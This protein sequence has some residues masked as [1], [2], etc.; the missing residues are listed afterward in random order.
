MS[1]SYVDTYYIIAQFCAPLDFICSFIW[2]PSIKLGLF[3][4]CR[5]AGVTDVMPRIQNDSKVIL[6]SAFQLAIRANLWNKVNSRSPFLG[7]ILR[8]RPLPQFHFYVPLPVCAAVTV[9]IHVCLQML[10]WDCELQEIYLSGQRF[11]SRSHARLV[12]GRSHLRLTSSKFV[13]SFRKRC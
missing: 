6:M 2:G 4:T 5:H 10:E 7:D 11:H 9:P 1:I 8:A 3:H 13:L 12:H